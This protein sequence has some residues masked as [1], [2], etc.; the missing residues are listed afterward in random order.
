MID[1][2]ITTYLGFSNW[3]SKKRMLNVTVDGI[4]LNEYGAKGLA[5][6]IEEMMEEKKKM[7]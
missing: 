1:S 3:V 7:L 4:H 5:H 2:L 6:L